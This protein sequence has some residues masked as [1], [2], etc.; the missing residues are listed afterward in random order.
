M[1]KLFIIAAGGS[2]VP[3]FLSCILVFIRLRMGVPFE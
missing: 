2:E 3:E 1:I